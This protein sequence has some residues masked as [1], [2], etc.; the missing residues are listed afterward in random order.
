MTGPGKVI[1]KAM[2]EAVDM[3]PDVCTEHIS[4]ALADAGYVLHSVGGSIM[5][6]CTLNMPGSIT[7]I[8]EGADDDGVSFAEIDAAAA[9]LSLA[10][11]AGCK[12]GGEIGEC[13]VASCP[14]R[15]AA[16]AA[17]QAA[18]RVRTAEDMDDDYYGDDE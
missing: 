9:A 16:R 12:H 4:R 11:H 1:E 10:G 8:D 6:S 18:R 15:T 2:A 17:L 5:T 13:T 7:E 3:A 14:C